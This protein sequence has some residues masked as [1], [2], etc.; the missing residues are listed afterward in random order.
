M[1]PLDAI[2]KERLYPLVCADLVPFSVNDKIVPVTLDIWFMDLVR[3][4]GEDTDQIDVSSNLIEV[5]SD[6]LRVL[7]DYR[8]EFNKDTNEDNFVL[9]DN[10]NVEDFQE[11]TTDWVAG[12]KGTF[13]F[14]IIDF[15]DYCQIP[16]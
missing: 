2:D 3:H 5:K 4:T 12:Y 7:L 1:S 13:I 15:S 6:M 10:I 8:A 11:F 14:E 16:Q 9:Q